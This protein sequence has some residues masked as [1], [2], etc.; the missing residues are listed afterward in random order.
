[1]TANDL[2]EAW[3][4][5]AQVR[6]V[7]FSAN[8][9][10]AKKTGWSGSGEGT[11]AVMSDSPESMI[12]A[13]RGTFKTE[14]GKELS[15]ENSFR[16]S[17]DDNGRALQLE[18]LRFGPQRPV[19][20]FKLVFAGP[21]LLVSDS[22][23]ACDQDCYRARMEIAESGIRLEWRVQGPEKDETISYLYE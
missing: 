9:N 13:E 21:N 4:R 6:R 14:S 16:W 17:F 10:S 15:F 12:F 5:L 22:P 8:S 20:L 2:R 19:F 23:H 3:R 11:V 18:H 1:M 7:S